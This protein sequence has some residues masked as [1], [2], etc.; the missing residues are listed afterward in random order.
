MCVE[1]FIA[2]IGDQEGAVDEVVFFSPGSE[3]VAFSLFGCR[4]GGVKISSI[5]DPLS[6]VP[7]RFRYPLYCESLSVLYRRFVMIVSV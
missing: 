4:P 7:E 2:V 5:D 1:S 3:N 6:S